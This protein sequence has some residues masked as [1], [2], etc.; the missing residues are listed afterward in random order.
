ML[1]R[2]D[3]LHQASCFERLQNFTVKLFIDGLGSV[4][5]FSMH[6]TKFLRVDTCDKFF[7]LPIVFQGRSSGFEMLMSLKTLR[8][9][10]VPVNMLMNDQCLCST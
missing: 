8:M 6:N 5:E 1:D 9:T 3:C 7:R 4:V 10:S 2:T